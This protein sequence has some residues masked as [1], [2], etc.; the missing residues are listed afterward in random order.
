MKYIYTLFSLFFFISCQEVIDLKLDT[1]PQQLVI[2]A[3]LDWKKGTTKA[4]PIV[5]IS[6]TEPYFG[7]TRSA[8]IPDAIVKIKT[9]TET[10]SLT[11]W[12]GTTTLTTHL[13]APLKGGSR[14]IY[15]DGITPHIGEIYQLEIQLKG[16][17]YTSQTKM[18]EAPE[19]LSKGIIQRE[20][21]GV[22][23]NQK[24]IR[25]T[26]DG[27]NDGTANAFLGQLEITNRKK[28]NYFALDD[29]YI[30]NNKF[31]FIV[32]GTAN[33]ALKT[34]DKI[35]TTLYRISPQY[36]E[37]VQMLLRISRGQGPYVIPEQPVGN[38]VNKQN[39]KRNPL[40]G[41]RVAQYSVNEYI[42]R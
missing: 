8:A 39:P 1:A 34:G 15:T 32:T 21:G 22:L 42:V 26:F 25:Y 20:N 35:V 3:S 9:S 2:E 17:T 12:D 10:Y 27:I 23:G 13:L 7:D 4:Y 28:A 41:F 5:N 18:L 14:Y 37:Y 33:E 11:L 29:N 6:Y 16:E 30:A 36:K 38:I 40:G 19:L 24:E 31:F